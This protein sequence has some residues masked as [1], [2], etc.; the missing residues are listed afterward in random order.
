MAYQYYPVLHPW[1][2]IDIGRKPPEFLN[3]IVEIAAG[4]RVKYEIDKKSGLIYVDRILFGPNFYPQNYGFI[5]QSYCDDGDPLDVIIYSQEA[6]VPRCIAP[7]RIIGAIEMID[8][9]KM[10]DKMI[11]VLEADPAYKNVN[12]VDDL[13]PAKL[14]EL[15]EFFTIYKRLEKKPVV[16]K[17][18]LHKEAALKI[19]QN[20]LDLYEKNKISLQIKE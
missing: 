4:S 12:D 9:D 5:P 2:S 1:H 15:K 10:D 7:C 14:D 16:V 20:A 19:V 17:D 13:P 3:G 6:L 11:A 8:N 18:I